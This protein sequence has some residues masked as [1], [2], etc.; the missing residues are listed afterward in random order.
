MQKASEQTKRRQL[1][2]VK[3]VKQYGEDGASINEMFEDCSRSEKVAM[4]RAADRLA[5]IGVIERLPKQRRSHP[6]ATAEFP[7]RYVER[8]HMPEWG[9]VRWDYA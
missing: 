5:Y 4:H 2:I 7:Y 3:R 6:N 9:W 8:Q 1:E